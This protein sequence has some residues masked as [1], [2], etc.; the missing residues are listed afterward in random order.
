[1][2]SII[3]TRQ[4]LVGTWRLVEY[5]A[6]HID[7]GHITY[8]MGPNAQGFL[9]YSADGFMSA[10]LMRPGATAFNGKDRIQGTQEE[11]SQAMSH[12]LAYC[13]PYDLEEANGGITVKHDL[14]VSSF[15]SWL[16]TEK[17]RL[18][19]LN[20]NNLELNTADAYIVDVSLISKFP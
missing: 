20:G 2:S 1:M 5:K 9:M 6:I 15:P 14:K 3:E 13:G 10:H 8:P 19:T 12:Y 7:T 11:Q 4:S 17:R 16:G 18:V